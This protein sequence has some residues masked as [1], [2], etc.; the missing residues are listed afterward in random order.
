MQRF[1]ISFRS[2]TEGDVNLSRLGG[3]NSMS[4]FDKILLTD[5]RTDFFLSIWKKKKKNPREVRE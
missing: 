5:K 2:L 4:L 1:L 3:V